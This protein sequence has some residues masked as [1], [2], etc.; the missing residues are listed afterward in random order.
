MISLDELSDHALYLADSGRW[1]DLAHIAP[2]LAAPWQ[3]QRAERDT[4]RAIAEREAQS[5]ERAARFWRY[6]ERSGA[7][8][9]R[10]A[11]REGLAREAQT[12]VGRAAARRAQRVARGEAQ[13][14]GAFPGLRR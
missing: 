11:T 13:P 12:V 2:W 1:R 9:L 6:W 14:Y 8:W 5:A 3:S 4:L 10:S 7:A